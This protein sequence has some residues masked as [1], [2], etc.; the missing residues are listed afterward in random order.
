MLLLSQ[1]AFSPTAELDQIPQNCQKLINWIAPFPTEQ[2]PLLQH[3]LLFWDKEWI[4]MAKFV[5]QMDCKVI[6]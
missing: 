5:A 4:T 1:K 3:E 6:A 2:I